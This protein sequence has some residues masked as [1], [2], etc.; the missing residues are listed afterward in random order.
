MSDIDLYLKNIVA[1]VLT[2]IYLVYCF[3]KNTPACYI[4][5]EL[6]KKIPLNV[7]NS[8]QN[9]LQNINQVKIK[10]ADLES[11]IKLQ[12]LLKTVEFNLPVRCFHKSLVFRRE[13]ERFI[14]KIQDDRFW[15]LRKDY[16]Y[17]NAHSLGNTFIPLESKFNKYSYFVRYSR[18]LLKNNEK[19]SKR[20]IKFYSYLRETWII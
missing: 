5:N 12:A 9:D 16:Y 17:L 18:Q 11:L 13:I 14:S 10:K 8:I 15:S 19:N 20:S 6:E 2:T 1:I 7:F 4:Y 3:G